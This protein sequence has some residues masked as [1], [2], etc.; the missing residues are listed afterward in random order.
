MTGMTAVAPSRPSTGERV[1][2]SPWPGHRKESPPRCEPTEAADGR[3]CP[4]IGPGVALLGELAGSGYRRPRFLVRRPGGVLVQL[5]Q[6]LYVTAA[7]S[8]G[9]RTP[10]RIAELVSRGY[11]RDVSAENVDLLVAKLRDLGVVADPGGGP[12]PAVP[13]DPLLGLTYRTALLSD[14]WTPRIA[15]LLHPLF[16]PA[17]IATAGLGLVAFDVWLFFVHG[18]GQGL[19]TTVQEPFVFVV[20]MALVV[21]SAALHELGHAAACSYGGGRPGTMGAGIYVAWPAF[22]TDVTDAY[23]LDRRGRLRTDLG[24]VYLNALVVLGLAAGFAWTRYEP[25]LLVCFI[26]Q[27]QIVQQMLPLLRLDGYYV[28]S[29]AVG[30]PDLFRRIG[31]I[32]R[33]AVPGRP[34]DP[35]IDDLKSRVRVVVTAWVLVLVPVLLVNLAFIVLSAPR[36]VATAWD[37]AA[38]LIGQLMTLPGVLERIVSGIQLVVLLVP[39]VGIAL[40]VGRTGRLAVSRARGWAEGSTRRGWVVAVGLAVVAAAILVSWWPDIRYTPYRTAD[41]GTLTDA[42]QDLTYFRD[43]RPVLRDPASA[44][45]ALPRNPIGTDEP[46]HDRRRHHPDHGAPTTTA[47]VV[48]ARAPVTRAPGAAESGDPPTGAWRGPRTE[49]AVATASP[50]VRTTD[51]GRGTPGSHHA[52]PVQL[53]PKDPAP[54]PRP[55]S[56]APP[57]EATTSAPSSPAPGAVGGAPATEAETAGPAPA[58]SPIAPQ[59]STEPTPQAVQPPPPSTPDVPESPTLPDPGA[60]TVPEP[61]AATPVE[62]VAPVEPALPEPGTVAVPDPGQVTVPT[63]TPILPAPLPVP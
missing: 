29:D 9:T 60:T 50:G 25:L 13:S 6:L 34:V 3:D 59:P 8:D 1:E 42:A 28:L 57:E 24:G 23:R 5:S 36:I 21:L 7:A 56:D 11:G 35:E 2:V 33:S 52:A 44:M 16:W 17:V 12:P 63:P 39:V 46:Q 38:R 51:R 54:I 14:R 45:R 40:V 48:D 32:L 30:V 55:T 10:A 19:R 4:A 26:V 58:P 27:V 61:E 62:P 15:R 31:P 41:R 53:I 47:R 43:G 18:L 49:P 22:Y 20:V 37:S